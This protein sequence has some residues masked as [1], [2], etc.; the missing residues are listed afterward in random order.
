L[1]SSRPNISPHRPEANTRDAADRR[2]PTR[3][4]LAQA[5]TAVLK[6]GGPRK[7]DLY[8]A[9][10]GDRQFVVK[11]FRRKRWHRRQLGRIQIHRETKAYRWLRGSPSVPALVG[12]VD[13][14][15]L[16]IEPVDGERL[17]FA[18]TRFHDA[19]R[20]LERLRTCLDRMHR[21]GVF[22]M[23]LR[24]RDNVLLRSDGEIVLVDL[25]GAV[26]LRPGGV[27]HRLLSRFLSVP[28]EAGYLKWK[29]L[30]APDRITGWERLSMERYRWLRRLWIFNPKPGPR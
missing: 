3:D 26:C 4:D 18:P 16:A 13:R 27:L 21:A 12:R 15:A 19:D 30:L 28:D 20:H 29:Q 8:L 25:A 10:D 14:Y 22:H 7:A 2:I 23:D 6:D 9:T 11:D 17:V 1:D 5:A 24:A